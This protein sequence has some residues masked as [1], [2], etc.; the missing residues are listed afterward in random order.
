MRQAVYLGGMCPRC[1]GMGDAER[2]RPDRAVRR[3]EVAQRGCADDPRLLDGRL[4]R[5][6]VQGVGLPMDKP[7]G[8]FTKKQ[9]ETM[10]YSASRPRSR[11]RASTSPSTGI[12]PKIQKSMLSKDVEAMQPH[13]RRFVERAVTF[14]DLPG[15]RGHPADQ[16]GPVLQDQGEEHRRALR[17]ADQ[18]SRRVAAWREGARASRR[19][20]RTAAPRSTRS[21]EIG[22]GYLS[23]DRSAGTLVRGRGAAHQDDPPPRLVADRRHLRVRRADHRSAPARHRADEPAAAP[24]AGQGQHRPGRRAQAGDDRDRRPRR[25]PRPRRRQRRRRGR[26]RGHLRAAPVQQ[27]RHRPAPGRPGVAQGRRARVDRGVRGPQGL[28]AQ[29]ARRSTSTSRWG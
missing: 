14:H 19:S 24:A 2:H 4:V 18:R 27:D 9:L 10:L 6:D 12:I 26:V 21:T 22:L 16:G 7:I 29:P 15:L 17:H 20:R 5:P 11:S 28:D 3:D 13:V 23:L 1:E 8:K 25:R